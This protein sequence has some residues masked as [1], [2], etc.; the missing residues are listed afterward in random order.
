MRRKDYITE[1]KSIEHI[2]TLL[3]AIGKGSRGYILIKHLELIPAHMLPKLPSVQQHMRSPLTTYTDI[4][5]LY[6]TM[7]EKHGPEC[8]PYLDQLLRF[9]ESTA[10]W[11]FIFQ[12]LVYNTSFFNYPEHYELSEP[13]YKLLSKDKIG[14]ERQINQ[15]MH[16]TFYY[17]SEEVDDQLE[18][19]FQKIQGLYHK[20]R[21]Y[22]PSFTCEKWEDTLENGLPFDDPN[23][24]ARNEGFYT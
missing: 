16:E 20:L 24:Y 10:L 2:E 5:Y 17:R 4:A 18:K 3:Q 23:W 12:S 19:L 6:E 21:E 9:A 22:N 11:G 13:I 8:F 15:F 7:Y 14:F 1:N